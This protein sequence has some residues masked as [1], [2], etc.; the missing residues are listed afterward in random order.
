MNAETFN[1]I[2]EQ[3]VA[4]IKATLMAKAAEYSS[5]D[6]RL[7]NFKVAARLESKPQ[8]PEQALWGMM[9][10]HLTS[11]IDIID[12]TGLGKYPTAAMRDEKFGDAI[13]YLILCEGLLI[14]H[15]PPEKVVVASHGT[16]ATMFR[17]ESPFPEIHHQPV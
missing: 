5:N 2:V 3:R 7:H 6:D 15:S 1:E 16:N 11:I 12:A 9:K 8:T 13:N 14:E 10:K 4:K 17:V